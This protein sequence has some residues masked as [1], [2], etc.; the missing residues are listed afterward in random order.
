MVTSSGGRSRFEVD[1][2]AEAEH[3]DA[4]SA[5]LHAGADVRGIARTDQFAY[6]L[7]GD[8]GHFGAPPNAVSAGAL[9]GG[10][11]SGS[12]TAVALGAAS[13]GL[14]TDTAGSIRVP[15]S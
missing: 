13:I 7:S 9:P 15:A 4:V 1:G 12:A 3:V 8:N 6:S 14:G 10:S 5:L 2:P 11:S